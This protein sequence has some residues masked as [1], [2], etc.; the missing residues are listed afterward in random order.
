MAILALII[1]LMGFG[2]LSDGLI[3]G[4]ITL[5]DLLRSPKAQKGKV[6]L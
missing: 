2:L 4:T 1:V 6:I 5:A 3:A